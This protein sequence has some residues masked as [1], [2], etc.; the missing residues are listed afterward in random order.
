MAAK[1]LQSLGVSL[2]AT[3]EKVEHMGAPAGL[4]AG[5]APFT[6][7]A[8]KV[9]ELA[10]REALYLGHKYVGTEHILLGLARE[11]EGV[12][13]KV[14]VSLGADLQRVRQQVIQFLPDVDT[15][16]QGKERAARSASRSQE[17][18][19]TSPS[20]TSSAMT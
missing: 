12:G 3:R 2:E 13:A 6:P 18:P 8:R 11:P 10:L 19:P 17:V 4:P 16:D 14:L 15:T 9:L 5:G 20:S 1:A 7:R